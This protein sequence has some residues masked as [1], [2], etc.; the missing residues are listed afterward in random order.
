MTGGIVNGLPIWLAVGTNGTCNTLFAP[1]AIGPAFVHVAVVPLVVQVH[2]LLLA[3]NVPNVV[4]VGICT[5]VV[6]GPTV[7]AVPILA[8]VTGIKLVTPSAG[9]GLG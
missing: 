3:G 4:P 1:L 8:T 2:P 6:I 9:T 7:G 5:V